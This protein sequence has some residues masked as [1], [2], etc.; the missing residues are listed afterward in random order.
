MSFWKL[1]TET[2]G[3]KGVLVMIAITGTF[4]VSSHISEFK[5]ES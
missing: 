2:I 3:T 1:A 5:A 4:Y